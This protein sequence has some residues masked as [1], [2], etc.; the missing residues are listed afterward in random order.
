MIRGAWEAV[1]RGGRFQAK[2]WALYAAF[3]AYRYDALEL[4]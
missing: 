2:A 1:K 4:G 3:Q